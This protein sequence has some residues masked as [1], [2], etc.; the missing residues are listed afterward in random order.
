MSV[1]EEVGSL[2]V[3][4]GMDGTGFQGGI[5]NLN[6]Q[7]KVVQA[8]FQAASAK[9][10][11]FSGATDQMNLKAESLNRQME[12]QKEKVSTLK[13]EFEKSAAAKGLDVKATQ[14]L[15]I[16]YLKAETQL[17]SL[18][19]ELRKTTTEIELQAPVLKAFGS[20]VN[21]SFDKVKTSATGLHSHLS[22]AFQ[23]IK[24]A[25]LGVGAT[26]AGGL[27]IFALTE[28]AVETG[29]SIY[30]LSKRLGVS[31]DEA[32]KMG[33][34]LKITDTEAKPFIG[35]MMRLDKGLESAGKNG[36]VT[37]KALEKY[38]VTLTDANGKL[39]PMTE[40][41]AKLSEAY[42]KAAETGNEDAFVAEILGARGQSMIP[43][44]ADY[45]EAK[46][47]AG[48]VKIFGV[49]V[50]AAHE[51]E[52]QLK[53]FKMQFSQFGMVVA[54]SMLPIAQQVMPRVMQAVQNLMQ[55]IKDHKTEIKQAI[56][57]IS[58]AFKSLGAIVIPIIKG[59]FEFIAQHGEAIKVALIGIGAGFAAL[60]SINTAISAFNSIKTAIT[61]A[62]SAIGLIMNP[63]GIAVIAVGV[64]AI[65]GYE[66]YKHWDEVKGNLSA[67]WATISSTLTATFGAMK[68]FLAQTWTEIKNVI[69]AV[70]NYI[71]PTIMGAVKEIA[72]FWNQIW[73]QVKQVFVE[74][75]NAM[76]VA[77]APVLAGLYIAISAAL[78]LIK[79]AWKDAWNLIKD[80]FKLAWD[81]MTGVLKVAWDLISGIIKVG[82]DLLTGN[83]SKAWEDMK[84]IFK[85]LWNDIKS[86]FKNMAG[87][88]VQWGKDLIQ[89]LIDGIKGMISGVVNAVKNVASTISS[90]LH[91][92]TPDEGPLAN[93]ES[94]MPDFMSGL[95]AGIE[96]NKHLV[97]S[98]I[99]GLVIDMGINAI[100][101]G[102]GA[103]AGSA[104][105]SVTIINRG[106]IVGSS[107]MDEFATIVSRK[108]AGQ[109]GLSSGGGW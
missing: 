80:T 41:V 12:I 101:T 19:N 15:Q 32:A 96:R 51:Q 26:L 39:L 65:A 24:L 67:V 3:K 74:V 56:N 85:N 88:A 87:D 48:K 40:Q 31:N 93:Y 91:F 14:D 64:L 70:W 100:V 28:K 79:G 66:L 42:E 2:V 21:E 1:N 59:L 34:M 22:N 60:K 46:E 94:W 18:E 36:N 6:Q 8:E 92:S 76:R 10:G 95:A 77:L 84:S 83:W 99:N 29:D 43:L 108:I 57:N 50:E 9:L 68:D 30:M 81:L 25:A 71:S 54:S 104:G 106:T 61:G 72:T 23:G 17:S 62:G 58:G 82:L 47:A 73:P 63:I 109:Y 11:G 78:G 16:K 27:G 35:T 53:A 97:R 5:S 4:I 49:D 44:L 69:T 13:T 38:S 102:S 103:I 45:K 86:L 98:A 89:G 55:T 52:V 37:T 105:P 33:Q 90:F 107:G 20:R 7:M 75:W